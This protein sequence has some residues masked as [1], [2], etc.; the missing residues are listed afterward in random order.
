MKDRE[1]TLDLDLDRERSP[2]GERSVL[3]I[4]LASAIGY[5]RDG[6]SPTLT[7]ACATPHEF[8]REVSRLEE[9]LAALR[10]R[11]VAALGGEAQPAERGA[12]EAITPPAAPRPSRLEPGLRVRDLMTR[13]VRTLQRNDPISLADELMKV[14][15]FRHVIVLDEEGEVS[16]LVSHRDIV[17]GALAWTLGVGVKAHQQALASQPVK[18]VM[19]TRLVFAAPDE[20]LEH[21]AAR[22]IERKI[23]CMP[24][25]DGRELVGILTEG[26]F[27]ALLA[28]PPA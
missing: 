23:G 20:P 6:G 27:L 28:G 1:S 2:E 8:D 15:R 7:Y 11:G 26:D 24:V 18:N 5:T 4:T 25:L 14:G 21:A 13:E 12:S 22:M 3:R 17:H 19:Q 9:E 10:V 16:G